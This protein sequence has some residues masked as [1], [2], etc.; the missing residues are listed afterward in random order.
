LDSSSD[1]SLAAD[2]RSLIIGDRIELTL[3]SSPSALRLPAGG[4]TL[5]RGMLITAP[6]QCGEA[7]GLLWRQWRCLID[8]FAN[9]IFKLGGTK[10]TL[11]IGDNRITG[12]SVAFEGVVP[13]S[14]GIHGLQLSLSADA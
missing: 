9:V 13:R 4:R 12:V 5:S 11:G 7:L 2:Q 1:H 3:N 8:N 14:G 10:I 6:K